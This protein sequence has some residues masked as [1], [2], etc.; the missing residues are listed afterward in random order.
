MPPVCLLSRRHFHL[1]ATD[2]HSFDAGAEEHTTIAIRFLFELAA[3]F[4]IFISAVCAEIPILF[5][6]PAFANELSFLYIPFFSS[7]DGPATEIF[8]IEETNGFLCNRC[9]C[10]AAAQC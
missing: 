3:E 5:V 10:N 6:G 4:E 7:V 9:Q 1:P 8:S 2:L